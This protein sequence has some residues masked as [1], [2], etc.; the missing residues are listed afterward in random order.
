MFMDISVFTD[1]GEIP[2]DEKLKEAIDNTYEIWKI[3]KTKVFELY[4]SAVKE[5][6]FPGVKYGWSFRIKDKKRAILYFL[7]REKFFKVAFLFGQK[8]FNEIMQSG[9]REAIK[10]ELKEARVYAEGRG[11]IIDVKDKSILDD[12][13]QLIQTKLKY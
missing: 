13:Q 9:I 1:K 2:N 8:A 7:P 5:W 11:I 6:N 12:I 4:P 3:I 10:S